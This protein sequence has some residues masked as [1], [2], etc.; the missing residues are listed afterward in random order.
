MIK[1]LLWVAIALFILLMFSRAFA[2][3]ANYGKAD[4]YGSERFA[5]INNCYVAGIEGHPTLKGA[6][7]LTACMRQ[8]G[9]QFC[10]DCRVFG[11]TGPHCKND[12]QGI[13]HSWC[14]EPQP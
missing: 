12:E 11:N 9:W 10:D 5:A 14:W 1:L 3:P 8:L 6:A 2:N 7:F 4:D 13:H